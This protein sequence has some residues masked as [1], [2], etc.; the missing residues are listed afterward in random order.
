[1]A[2]V[3]LLDLL[4]VCLVPVEDL[5]KLLR[6]RRPDAGA[7]LDRMQSAAVEEDRITE[8]NMTQ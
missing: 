3:Y 6:Q 2:L 1:V 8:G 4:Q 7:V 5:H